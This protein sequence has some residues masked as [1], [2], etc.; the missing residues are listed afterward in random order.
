MLD[1][2]TLQCVS[3]ALVE[4]VFIW[5]NSFAGEYQQNLCSHT[6]ADCLPCPSRLPS[7][8][9]HL[10]REEA[11]PGRLWTPWFIECFKNRTVNVGNC[12]RGVFDPNLGDCVAELD[13]SNSRHI[14]RD[15]VK[16]VVRYHGWLLNL[17]SS[18]YTAVLE[19]S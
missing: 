12:G 5:N 17:A 13:K 16:I 18:V 7:C 3:V 10:N 15:L 8:V 1:G 2:H 19:N 9:G 6:D 4:F 11:F 14:L